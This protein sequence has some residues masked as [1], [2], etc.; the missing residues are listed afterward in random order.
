ML[1]AHNSTF[2]YQLFIRTFTLSDK[3]LTTDETL[4]FDNVKFI[5]NDLIIKYT[6]I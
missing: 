5:G 4:S 6:N 1:E 2:T 3:S